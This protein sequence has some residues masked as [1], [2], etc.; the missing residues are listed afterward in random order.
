MALTYK[1]DNEQDERLNPSSEASNDLYHQE[2]EA[3]KNAGSSDP[4]FDNIVNN[5]D[6][7]AEEPN[8]NVAAAKKKEEKAGE[9]ENLGHSWTTNVNGKKEKLT[10]K[11][12]L[13][14][15]GP[16]GLIIT[17][18]LGG[19]GAFSL[20]V[21]P[22]IGIVHLKEVLV[23]DLN[24]Q[25]GA[26]SL[27]S[28]KLLRAKLKSMQGVGLCSNAVSI[29]CKFSTMSKRQVNKFKKAG[30]DVEP[31]EADKR[32]GRTKM[33]SLT[34][35]ATEEG[36]PRVTV[37]NP[38]ELRNHL[39]ANP[40]ARSAMRK[41]FNP[42]F[43]GLWD[44]VSDRVFAKF[45][46]DKSAK[47]Q[48]ATDEERDKAVDAATAGEK[49]G[50]NAEGHYTDP[51]GRNY[52]LDENGNKVFETGDGANP[53]KFKSISESNK[54]GLADI[55]SK[56]GKSSIG[57]K[58]V[59]GTLKSGLKGLSVIG[60][61]DTACT[62]YNAA[63]AV[64]AAAKVARA[65]QLVQF[66]MVFLNVADR[67]K[68]GTATEGEVRYLGD[69]FTAIDGNKTV[70]DESSVWEGSNAND[71][72][73]KA[74]D[75]PY[76]NMSGFDSP[77]FKTAAYNEAPLLTT[78]DLQYTVGGG[79]TG[80]LANVLDS[81]AKV[82]GGRDSIR[83]TCKVVQSWW[84][85]AAGLIAGI[86]SAIGTFGIATAVS[87]GASV[88]IGFALPFLESALGD[89][90]A[91]TVVSSHTKGVD[92]GDATFSGSGQLMG[93]M[94]SGHGMMPAS[95]DQL[96]SYMVL[97]NQVKADYV[98]ADVYDA[99]QTPLDIYNQ[100]SFLGSALRTINPA[101][102]KSASGVSSMLTGIPSIISS[103]VASVMPHVDASQS[104]NADRYKRCA[105][106]DGY[107]ELGIDAD[108]F[109]NVRYALT[110][111]QLALDPDDAAQWMIDHGQAN[112]DGSPKSSDY[113]DWV[114][115][116]TVRGDGWGESGSDDNV[117]DKDVG[118][119][120]VTKDK[121]ADQLEKLKYYGVAYMDKQ[122]SDSMDDSIPGSDETAMFSQPDT[123]V[124]DTSSI[125]DTAV[126][127]PAPTA[128]Q[129]EPNKEV[130]KATT[131]VEPPMAPKPT[132]PVFSLS[133]ALANLSIPLS[134]PPIARISD[135]DVQ[136]N[137]PVKTTA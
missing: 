17:L 89:I 94:A 2:E 119:I 36:G 131:V 69:N 10:A 16:M 83:S 44:K 62:V 33:T 132:T 40:A 116:C 12:F 53:D 77:G 102:L 93:D 41:A 47:A 130:T 18:L 111:E 51:D 63:R 29:R 121:N 126:Q 42:T 73:A 13:K 72:V 81:I 43:S 85:R 68:A 25:V 1:N 55:A 117:S 70:I 64:A 23:G 91:G 127:T 11:G 24:D 45:K 95:S 100:Y 9:N 110:P 27:R 26:M 20:I 129:A 84:A 97:N 92:S 99:K 5:Y 75:N 3:G 61:A 108:V 105:G 35:P 71:A 6:K 137:I 78:R 120:C 79:L 48:G 38:N 56:A 104:F 122:I 86:V 123:A 15:K 59:S 109:C 46:T 90:I 19:G 113:Q 54:V 8:Y 39:I 80:T 74:H 101:I 7:T 134:T 128:P 87:I 14:K 107:R 49:A 4:E 32:F 88:A 58:A 115:F 31:A 65:L 114:D 28:D 133:K 34:F 66:A 136:L 106:D 76:Y 50:I 98:A 96:Q 103:G 67:I 60:A 57:S 22:G 125:Q 30:F 124:A 82:L 112:E 37:T 52:V 135:T 118:K 21:A